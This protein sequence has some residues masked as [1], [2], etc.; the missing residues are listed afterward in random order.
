MPNNILDQLIVIPLS[1][2]LSRICPGFWNWLLLHIPGVQLY[3]L[4][5]GTVVVLVTAVVMTVVTVA[6]AI[7]RK[8]R[9]AW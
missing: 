1:D 7:I 5:V 9:F 8:L 4:M 6:Q 3:L 2:F